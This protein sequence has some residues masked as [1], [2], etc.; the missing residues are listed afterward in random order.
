MIHLSGPCG[1][2]KVTAMRHIG[3]LLAAV[4]ALC[5]DGHAR[6]ESDPSS[7]AILAV[8]ISGDGVPELRDQLSLSIAAGASAEG[9]RVVGL[10]E[11]LDAMAAS[12]ELIGCMST[13]CL[14]RI[15]ELFDVEHFLKVTVEAR[16]ADYTVRAELLHAAADDGVAARLEQSCSVCTIPELN[17]ATREL[18]SRLL[19]GDAGAAFDVVIDT[20]PAG[21][22]LEID[23]RPVGSGPYL[24]TLTSGEHH[25]I[26]HLGDGSS[27][28]ETITV[29]ANP[30]EGQRFAI[31]LPDGAATVAGAGH[32]ERPYRMWKWAAAGGSAAAML[33]G[34]ILIAVDGNPT[35]DAPGDVQCPRVADTL[36]GGI[37]SL[38]VGVGL[39]AVATWM[40]L[41]DQKRIGHREGLSIDSAVGAPG[42]SASWRWRF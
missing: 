36:T 15:G 16:G 39:G 22:A 26:A 4:L 37:A 25:V 1:G 14:A 18:V 6:A 19:S 34:V 28:E 42:A 29:A 27:V 3:A 21:A 11:A 24:G 7:V 38:G 32:E 40:F 31:A 35:C 2:G 8:E 17:D 10:E 12:P 30:G 23:G 41:H 5:S 9:R 13:S 20:V 33:T